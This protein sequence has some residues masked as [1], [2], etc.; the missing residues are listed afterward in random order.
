MRRGGKRDGDTH[1]DPFFFLVCFFLSLEDVGGA[2]LQTLSHQRASSS[3]MTLGLTRHWNHGNYKLPAVTTEER[4]RGE[5]RKT[6]KSKKGKKKRKTPKEAKRAILRHAITK[7]HRLYSGK[8]QKSCRRWGAIGFRGRSGRGAA[9]TADFLSDKRGGGGEKE[10]KQEE[11]GGREA[12][13][14]WEK[15]FSAAAT[16]AHGAERG[17]RFKGRL[18]AGT[19]K[20]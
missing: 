8:L 19:A 3:A 11:E 18:W 17:T 14:R 6:K 15:M 16:A 4:L 10:E 13:A 9:G 20:K 2:K 7:N 12:T 1:E 5:E